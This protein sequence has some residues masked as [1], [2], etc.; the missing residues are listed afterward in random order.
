MVTIVINSI[1]KPFICYKTL[2]KVGLRQYNGSQVVLQVFC[3]IGEGE[4]WSHVWVGFMHLCK[5][6]LVSDSPGLTQQM[7][8]LVLYFIGYGD[9][10][11]LFWAVCHSWQESWFKCFWCFQNKEVPTLP[12]LISVLH[13]IKD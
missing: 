6:L 7:N 10:K 2:M 11:Q 5:I 1:G 12:A 13:L 9:N 3:G 8:K 4:P